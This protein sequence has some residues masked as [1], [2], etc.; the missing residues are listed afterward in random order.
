MLTNTGETQLVRSMGVRF[1]QH[2]GTSEPMAELR[3]HLAGARSQV[4][5]ENVSPDPV[6][7]EAAETRLR[8][9]PRFVQP[10]I[11]K[12]CLDYARR[13]GLEEITHEVM[14]AAQKEISSQ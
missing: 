5:L 11:H 9:H 10:V 6:W 7:T 4:F 14:D 2:D 8:Q 1:G 3:T 12:N 13:H